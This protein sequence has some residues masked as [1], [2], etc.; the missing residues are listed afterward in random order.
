VLFFFAY[1]KWSDVE[2]AIAAEDSNK[3]LWD[4]KIRESVQLREALINS[5]FVI[6]A[7]A[8]IYPKCF[9]RPLRNAIHARFLLNI[10]GI[11]AKYKALP[12]L[13]EHAL[14]VQLRYLLNHQKLGLLAQAQIRI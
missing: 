8:G 4:S 7:K 9:T 10:P 1:E 2:S 6:P 3:T 14:V 13:A 11:L 12:T 5:R